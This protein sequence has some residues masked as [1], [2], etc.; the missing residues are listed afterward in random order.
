VLHQTTGEL[1]PAA[2]WQP[3]LGRELGQIS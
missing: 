1:G 2:G 3:A